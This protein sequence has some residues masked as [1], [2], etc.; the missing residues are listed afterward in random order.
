MQCGGK[1][2]KKT[3]FVNVFSSA[4]DTNSVIHGHRKLKLH[5]Q[6]VS[7]QELRKWFPFHVASIRRYDLCSGWYANNC[8]L[9][10]NIAKSCLKHDDSTFPHTHC[11]CRHVSTHTHTHIYI[12]IRICV[13][14]CVYI[15]VCVCYIYLYNAKPTG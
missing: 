14:V 1:H 6:K 12:Y 13:Y 8:F 11:V 4:G 9:L 7:P 10:Y 5:D 3:S 2:N 15:Y